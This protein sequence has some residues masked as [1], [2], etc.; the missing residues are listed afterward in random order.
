M[1]GENAARGWEMERFRS[2]RRRKNQDVL[3]GQKAG[4]V[5]GMEGTW[6]ELMRLPIGHDEDS[7]SS[8]LCDMAHR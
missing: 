8:V 1:G 7:Q 3:D 4:E 2:D 6:Q 5:V